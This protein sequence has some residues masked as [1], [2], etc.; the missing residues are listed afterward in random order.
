[1]YCLFSHFQPL[2]FPRKFFVVIPG[3]NNPQY[4]GL[5]GKID[6]K[7]NALVNV[8]KEVIFLGFPIF[9]FTQADCKTNLL[10]GNYFSHF[11]SLGKVSNIFAI[12]QLNE[13]HLF[14][15]L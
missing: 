4:F 10:I 5:M 3:M 15:L 9:L 13:F 11:W 12:I 8:T 6:E 14:S 1:M 7:G 2:S